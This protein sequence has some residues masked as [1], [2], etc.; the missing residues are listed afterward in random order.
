M[1]SGEELHYC[2]ASFNEKPSTKSTC[3]QEIC[4]YYNVKVNRVF[5]IIHDIWTSTQMWLGRFS[6]HSYVLFCCVFLLYSWQW[7]MF[8][9][10]ID[11]GHR[12]IGILM[13]PLW[14][15][16]LIDN[17]LQSICCIHCCHFSFRS[18]S[19]HKKMIYF[20]SV[21]LGLASGMCLSKVNPSRGKSFDMLSG[22]L[23]APTCVDG[24]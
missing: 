2:E 8:A 5:I 1:F 11:N 22:V 7:C 17:I 10:L 15:I 18:W 23:L 12:T 13:L 19:R 16:C 20:P 14:W 6:G 4:K 3:A 9:Y 21:G 24:V